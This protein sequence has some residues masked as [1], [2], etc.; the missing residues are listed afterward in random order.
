[1]S[2]QEVLSQIE[3]KRQECI[4]RGRTPY[5]LIVNSDVYAVV[6]SRPD[7]HKAEVLIHDPLLEMAGNGPIQWWDEHEYDDAEEAWLDMHGC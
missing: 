1:M 4:A 5:A 2:E 6:E 7:A 3:T